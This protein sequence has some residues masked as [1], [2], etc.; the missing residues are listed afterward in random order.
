MSR[1]A[2]KPRRYEKQLFTPENLR[3]VQKQYRAQTRQEIHNFLKGK[4]D[5]ILIGKPMKAPYWLW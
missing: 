3:I 2:Y 5:D 1:S 4:Q